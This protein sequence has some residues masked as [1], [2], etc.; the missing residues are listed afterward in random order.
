MK[1][2]VKQIHNIDG[3]THLR[4]IFAHIY[5]LYLTR[6]TTEK[7]KSNN[8]NKSMVPAYLSRQGL[9][10]LLHSSQNLQSFPSLSDHDYLLT[11]RKPQLELSFL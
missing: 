3:K 4:R 6:S 9:V 1:I 7:I 11:A 2:K 8:I 5:I 10:G